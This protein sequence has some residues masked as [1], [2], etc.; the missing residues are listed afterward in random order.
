MRAGSALRDVI[1]KAGSREGA[2]YAKKAIHSL[3]CS[4]RD[5]RAFA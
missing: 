5:L 4:V 3:R 1:A 2:K